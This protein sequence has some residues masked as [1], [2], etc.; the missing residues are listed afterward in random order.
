MNSNQAPKR[1]KISSKRLEPI[2]NLPKLKRLMEE[3]TFATHELRGE[4]Q[5]TGDLANSKATEFANQTNDKTNKDDA[6]FEQRAGA[7][8]QKSVEFV[9]Q[10]Q[11]LLISEELLRQGYIESFHNFFSLV[12]EGEA[13]LGGKLMQVEKGLFELRDQL[14]RAEEEMAQGNWLK[15][16]SVYTDIADKYLEAKISQAARYFFEKVAALLQT[17]VNEDKIE[18]EIYFQRF[19]STKLGL[20]KCF[21]LNTESAQALQILEEIYIKTDKSDEYH[22]EIAL[23]LVNLYLKLGQSEEDAKNYDLA[24]KLLQKCLKVCIESNMPK[25]ESTLILRIS[26][27]LKRMGRTEQSIETI[28]AHRQKNVKLPRDFAAMF[29]IQSFKLLASCYE[30][31]GDFEEAENN[32]KN[33][34]ELLKLN[35]ENKEFYAGKPSLKLGDISWRKENWKEGVKYY[36]DYFE[37]T[38]KAKAKNR[39]LI[40]HARVT[41]S[42]AKGFDEFESFLEYFQMSRNRMEDMISFKRN[43]RIL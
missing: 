1:L 17:Y 28:K 12:I 13:K 22:G 40:N 15:V 30:K 5:M 29:D 43:R 20:V 42:V 7:R 37:E 39:Q 38:L 33:F 35:E 18:L 27:V 34:Y 32:Y 26:R 3:Q 10:N 11:R 8:A 14:V 2:Q 16:I 19:I 36:V 21:D 31:L 6:D 9:S 23:Q 41:L 24:L 4:S 25:E